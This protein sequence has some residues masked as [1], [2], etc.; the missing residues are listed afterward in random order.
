LHTVYEDDTYTPNYAMAVT[1]LTTAK[2]LATNMSQTNSKSRR[3]RCRK[4][5]IILRQTCCAPDVQTL[6][7]CNPLRHMLQWQSCPASNERQA[8]H[9]MLAVQLHMCL[10]VLAQV[11]CKHRLQ[12]STCDHDY[13]VQLVVIGT[14]LSA[15]TSAYSPSV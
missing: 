9:Q 13:T 11:G 8:Q 1:H 4:H 3:C 15:L 5:K 12:G 14:Q 7:K 2:K 6:L 10:L